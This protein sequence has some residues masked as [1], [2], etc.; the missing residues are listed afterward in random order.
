ME[1]CYVLTMRGMVVAIYRGYQTVRDA[2]H[3]APICYEHTIHKKPNYSCIL[4]V[5]MNEHVECN[6]HHT[7]QF[8]D[9]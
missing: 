2:L 9:H 3:N 4:H 6:L 8:A 7:W 1:V 5:R